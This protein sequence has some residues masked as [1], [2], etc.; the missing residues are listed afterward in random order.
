MARGLGDLAPTHVGDLIDAAAE[1]GR[2]GILRH[3]IVDEFVN[4][5]LQPGLLILVHRHEPCGALGLNGR[6]GIGRSQLELTRGILVG[7]HGHA[8]KSLSFKTP[9]REEI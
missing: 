4:P 5:N 1:L 3:Q 8:G 2:I 7:H 6:H 9:E